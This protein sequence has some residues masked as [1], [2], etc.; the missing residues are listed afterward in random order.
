M[1][2]SRLIK[3]FAAGCVTTATL[4]VARVASALP[5]PEEP[6]L[7]MPRDAS[8]DGW[9]IDRLIDVTNYFV[10]GL[11]AFMLLWMI[12]A[13]VLHNKNHEAEYDDGKKKRYWPVPVG[14]A[15]FCFFVVDGNLFVNS[16][17]DMHGVFDNFAKAES[18]EGAVRIQI[19]AHQWAWDARY[20]G[21]D[22]K[23]NTKDDIL[24]LNDIRVPVGKPA[25]FQIASVDVVHAFYV[26]NMRMKKDAMPGMINSMWFRP[27]QTG[28]FDIGCA[29]HCGT[30]HYK[31]KGMLTVLPQEEYDTWAAEMSADSA[32][33]FDPDDPSLS[34]GWEWKSRAR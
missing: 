33:R 5:Q 13:I 23:F 17:L 16:T 19:N 20:A 14:I 2:R 34:W 9:R 30:H 6:G 11:L 29:Q 21:P 27:V 1:T 8:A 4:A 22:G 24:T 7:G 25:V 3:A 31:M 26:P 18:E 12:T 10:V 15:M 32:R 28:E